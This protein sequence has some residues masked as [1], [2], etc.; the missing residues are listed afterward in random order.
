VACLEDLADVLLGLLAVG[1]LQIVEGDELLKIGDEGVLLR[2]TEAVACGHEVGVVDD[3]DERPYLGTLVDA[4]LG[5]RLCD[6]LGILVDTSNESMTVR[7]ARATIVKVANNNGLAAS[8][9]ASQDPA[10]RWR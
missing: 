1:L 9:T 4:A 2:F 5:H 3:L 6:S 7:S 8:E 10:A